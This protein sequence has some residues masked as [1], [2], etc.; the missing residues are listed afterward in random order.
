MDKKSRVIHMV[1]FRQHTFIIL[2]DSGDDF[3]FSY[4]FVIVLLGKLNVLREKH[5]QVMNS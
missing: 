1:Q 5:I 2:R 4:H 3:Q